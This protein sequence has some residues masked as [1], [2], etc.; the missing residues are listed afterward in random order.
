MKPG[1]DYIDVSVGALIFNDKGEVF[2]TM[3]PKT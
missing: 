2:Q 1:I 3:G